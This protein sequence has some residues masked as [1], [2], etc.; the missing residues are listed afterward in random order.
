[1]K[2]YLLKTITCLAVSALPAIAYAQ[3]AQTAAAP[4]PFQNERYLLIGFNILL[5]IVIVALGS[6]VIA[7]VDIKT[8]RIKK[9]R[10]EGTLPAII[11]IAI[12]CCLLG[13]GNMAMAQEAA[14]AAA[15]AP[16]KSYLATLPL[17]VIVMCFTG[18]LQFIVIIALAIIQQ[19]LITEPKATVATVKVG[20]SR[21][22][23]FLKS[24]TK[25]Q[26]KEEEAQLDL[27]HD[28][29]GIR[30]LDNNIPAWWKYAF[31][32]TIV[33]GAVYMYRMFVSNTMPDQ[34]TELIHAN[35]VAQLQMDEYL[36]NSANN[37]DE[38]TVVMQDAAGVTSGAKIYID[39]GCNA[40]HGAKGEGGVGP[41]LTDEYWIHKG[42]IKDI[43]Y[44]VKYGWPEKGM[45]A[46]N[47]D[48]SPQEIA[49][50][51]S[52]IK[53]IHGTKPANAKEPQGEI[54]NDDVAT[55]ST[56]ATPPQASAN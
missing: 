24:F 36:K 38:K 5:L 48:L 26:T 10:N 42:S 41:N 34:I 47:T 2:K 53:S 32:G 6:T 45:K 16:P 23:K 19:Q 21:L 11:T 18:L 49:Q 22:Q 27:H 28:Y 35:Q 40:C 29:D 44:S 12:I 37:I 54:Y 9:Q 52:Y 46:W 50:V 3:A 25:K 20:E 13:S 51:S 8:Q 55:D 4:A 56:S 43:F 17:D 30:E 14:E 7:A 1:M 15:P 33:I 31:Y 39:K